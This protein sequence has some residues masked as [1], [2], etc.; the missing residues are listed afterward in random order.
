MATDREIEG[1]K[2]N[3][4]REMWKKEYIKNTNDFLQK[5]LYKYLD[6]MYRKRNK[7]V[8]QNKEILNQGRRYEY[9][10]NCVRINE[11]Q[12]QII[13]FEKAIKGELI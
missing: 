4:F 9:N 7:I 11:L 3:E 1:I 2:V 12:L 13:R 6:S 8:K 10:Q 5:N